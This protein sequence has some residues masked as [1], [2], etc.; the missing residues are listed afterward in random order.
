MLDLTWEEKG[1]GHNYM[2]KRFAIDTLSKT[3][4]KLKGK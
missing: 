4:L 2:T 1:E 3:L